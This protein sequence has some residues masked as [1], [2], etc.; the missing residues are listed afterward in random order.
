M[1]VAHYERVLDGRDLSAPIEKRA[2]YGEPLAFLMSMI[3][4]LGDEC[5]PWPYAVGGTKNGTRP[6]YGSIIIEGRMRTANNVICELAHGPAP[7][8]EHE[9]A[10]SCRNTLCVNPNH[11]RWAT[12]GENETDKIAHGTWQYRGPKAGKAPYP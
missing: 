7:T 3:G 6:G 4:H 10:H 12:P 1:C 11:V 5:V 9:S 8:P 2:K